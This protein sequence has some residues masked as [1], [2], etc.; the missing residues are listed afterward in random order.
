MAAKSS[1]IDWAALAREQYEDATPEQRARIDAH[2]AARA[3]AEATRGEVDGHFERLASPPRFAR[4][5]LERKVEA[6]WTAPVGVTI[7]AVGDRETIRF[8]GGVT[9][10]E[11]YTL[12]E[13]F[14]AMLE[15]PDENRARPR[16]YLC[17]GTPGR[18]DAL[19][20]EP[21]AVAAYL[22]ER[23]PGLFPDAAP[24]PGP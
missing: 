2:R 5:S 12:D 21:A 9:G 7:E 19:W 10:H 18:Y 16:F 1:G 11:S 22:R 14:A 3:E 4:G 15:D 8:H 6:A 20:V 23:R 13:R 24:P 17:A